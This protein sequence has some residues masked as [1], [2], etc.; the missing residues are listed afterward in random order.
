MI[1][2]R[3][4]PGKGPLVHSLLGS[5]APFSLFTLSVAQHQEDLYWYFWDNICAWLFLIK[6]NPQL[7]KILPLKVAWK[8]FD[9]LFEM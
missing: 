5:Y 2:E 3:L 6:I 7:T 4:A 9:C 8:F 1:S